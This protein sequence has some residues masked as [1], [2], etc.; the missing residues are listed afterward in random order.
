M[1]RAD[2]ALL[3]VVERLLSALALIR[4]DDALLDTAGML[5]PQ[6][7]RSLDAVHLAAVLRIA[8]VTALVTYDRRMQDAARSLDVAVVAPG[9]RVQA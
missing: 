9:Q 2:D 4:V 8:P 5:G 1:R 7:V 6:I 3:P